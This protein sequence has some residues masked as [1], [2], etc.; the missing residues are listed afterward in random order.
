MKRFISLTLLGGLTVVCL[1]WFASLIIR[2]SEEAAGRRGTARARAKRAE[3]TAGDILIGVPYHFNGA[4]PVKRGVTLATREI[5][6]AGGVLGRP[7]RLLF[8]D[9]GG[10]AGQASRVAQAFADNLDIVA[11]IGHPYSAVAV[12]TAIMYEYPG[13]LFISPVSMNSHLT[14]AGYKKVFRVNITDEAFSKKAV[15]LAS[16]KGYRRVAVYYRNDEYGRGMSGLFQREA[17]EYNVTVAHT[18]SYET[19]SD[20][21]TFLKEMEQWK[22][23]RILDAIFLVCFTQEAPDILKA[24]RKKG[25]E[26]PIIGALTMDDE[27][28]VKEA[29]GAAEGM[30][31]LTIFHPDMPFPQTKRF[32]Q[33]FEMAYGEQ[34][35]FYDA[36][37]YDAV[38]LLAHA[39]EK[40]GT[41]VPGRVAD[42]LR[43][44][45]DWPG[46]TGPHTATENGDMIKP[47]VH[48]KVVKGRIEYQ[49]LLGKGVK[50]DLS[51]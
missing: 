34:P 32:V 11:V 49:G 43:A 20:A 39:M 10:N 30:T 25:I 40:A 38:R 7:L 5:N 51:Q 42:A 21:R 12:P 19:G 9:D 8:R 28:I 23:D 24:I 35:R 47:I 46:V 1:T 36:A 18:S 6:R 17:E 45:K 16:R 2:T 44:V 27:W 4:F 31:V 48:V 29:R 41:T 3:V 33:A 14:K 37:S 15:A 22:R 13:V 26:C 50:E